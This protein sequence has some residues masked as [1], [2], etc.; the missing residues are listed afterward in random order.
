MDVK[1]TFLNGD[2]CEEVFMDQP[3]GFK[4]KVIGKLLNVLRY[5]QGTKEHLLTYR[6]SDNLEMTINPHW[7]IFL[8]WQEELFLEKCQIDT[9]NYLN[10]ISIIFSSCGEYLQDLNHIFMFYS[11]DT[12]YMFVRKKVEEFQTLVEDIPT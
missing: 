10:N 12:K 9:Y 5:L 2:L 11:F 3:N 8:C 4:E 7:D 1:S 6:R